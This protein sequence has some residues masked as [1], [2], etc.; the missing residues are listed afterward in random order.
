MACS[1]DT[2]SVKE[3]ICAPGCKIVTGIVEFDDSYAAAAGEAFDLSD[4]LP[5]TV[6]NCEINGVV[7]QA[8]ALVV[9]SYV[10][11]T[12]PTNGTIQIVW[13]GAN[14]GDSSVARVFEAFTNEGDASAYK[15]HFLAIGH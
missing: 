8:D 9:P 11:G 6:V 15:F 12:G 3:F 10:F 5:H 14:S 4:Y 7:S 1:I 2:A 13:D